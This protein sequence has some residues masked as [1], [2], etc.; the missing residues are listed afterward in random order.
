M[1]RHRRRSRLSQIW[2]NWSEYPKWFFLRQE[3]CWTL[4]LELQG[5]HLR[6][7]S[8]W[9]QFLGAAKYHSAEFL[10]ACP[11]EVLCRQWATYA[12]HPRLSLT[13]VCT[14]WESKPAAGQDWSGKHTS[15][16][17]FIVH[18]MQV[19]TTYAALNYP[20]RSSRSSWDVADIKA[21][22]HVISNTSRTM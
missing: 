11:H 20:G 7:A 12:T 10:G 4:G 19:G 9:Y 5:S 2:R 15:W 8:S 14:S 17:F 18:L 13:I 21:Q 3:I 1:I 16:L 6:Q 22:Y